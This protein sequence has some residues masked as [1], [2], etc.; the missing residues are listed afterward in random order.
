MP[1]IPH[2]APFPWRRAFN[3]ERYTIVSPRPNFDYVV[4]TVHGLDMFE[5][6]TNANILASAPGSLEILDEAASR[7]LFVHTP[8]LLD[9]YL[10]LRR[11]I[12]GA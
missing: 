6:M 2:A 7:R 4:A 1:A 10:E 12:T 11:T 5:E 3:G 8:D 9:R